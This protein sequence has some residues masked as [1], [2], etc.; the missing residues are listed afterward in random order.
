MLTLTD[1]ARK[2]LH[3]VCGRGMLG[4]PRGRLY[5]IA[6]ESN[7]AEDRAADGRAARR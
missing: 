5:E 6:N 3:L 4:K 1:P 7:I 2:N